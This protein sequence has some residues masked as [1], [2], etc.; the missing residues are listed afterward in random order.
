MSGVWAGQSSSGSLIT[1]AD[2][3]EVNRDGQVQGGGEREAIRCGGDDRGGWIDDDGCEAGDEDEDL[4]PI[5]RSRRRTS[6]ALL[7]EAEATATSC[8]KASSQFRWPQKVL[9]S[10]VT[11]DFTSS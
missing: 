7:P 5:F 4:S 8:R 10:F 2:N 3:G 6:A 1:A 9:F 11:S